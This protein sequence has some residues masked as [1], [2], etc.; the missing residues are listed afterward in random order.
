MRKTI[1]VCAKGSKSSFFGLLESRIGY[2]RDLG[3]QS[4]ADNYLCALKKLKLFRGSKDIL[5][6]DLSGNLM[7]EFQQYL[8][9]KRLSRNTISLYMRNLRAAYNYAVDEGIVSDNRHPFRKVFTGLEKTRKRACKQDIIRRLIALPL[10]EEALAQ[11]RDFFLFSIYTQGMAFVDVAH[12]TRANL[13]NGRLVYS[14][15]KTNQRIE[16]DLLSPALR[17]IRKYEEG[18]REG[19]YLFPILYNVK[20]GEPVKYTTALREYNRRLHRI[21][22]RLD[23]SSHLSSYTAR[24]TWASIA[25]WMGVND[26]V[27]SEAMGHNNLATTVIYLASLDSDIIRSANQVVVSSLTD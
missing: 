10:K 21:S 7:K 12:L 16:I 15:R 20:N 17:I 13:K 5:L 22:V 6:E 3:K 8:I 19:D 25:K 4:T 9:D 23:L 1:D 26:R 27:I 18:E 2:F 11:V 24:H 14:R